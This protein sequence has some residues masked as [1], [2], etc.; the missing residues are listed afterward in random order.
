MEPTEVLEG[1]SISSSDDVA[2]SAAAS[3][4]NRNRSRTIRAQEGTAPCPT[5]GAT[6]ESSNS[7]AVSYVY[8][9]GRIEARFPRPS[10]EKEF[11]QATG[12][13][14]TKG[15]T[16]RQAFYDVLKKRENRYLVR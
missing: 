2:S 13:A 16:D 15:K 4:E 6:S 11:A 5:C 9:L 10:V 14:D 3:A 12:R 1:S 7:S 8:A